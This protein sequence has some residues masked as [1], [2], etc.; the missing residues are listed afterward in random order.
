MDVESNVKLSVGKKKA[1]DN[2]LSTFQSGWQAY[3]SLS[4]WLDNEENGQDYSFP[5]VLVTFRE[6]MIVCV[7]LQLS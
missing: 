2:L 3:N 4:T 5:R 7:A 6:M 1:T